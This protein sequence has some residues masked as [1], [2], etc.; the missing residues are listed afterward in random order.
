MHDQEVDAQLEVALI[1][2]VCLSICLNGRRPLKKGMAITTGNRETFAKRP[3]LPNPGVHDNRDLS[4]VS[5]FNPQNTPCIPACPVKCEAYFSRMVK[6]FA[7]LG[8]EPRLNM[9]C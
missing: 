5:N 8:L 1:I 3:L 9:K 6:I 2:S 4:T 7:F